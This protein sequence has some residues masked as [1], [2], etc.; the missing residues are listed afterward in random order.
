LNEGKL[1]MRF[2]VQ[3]PK[4]TQQAI[5]ANST[6]LRQAH[7]TQSRDMNSILHLQRTIGNQGV[8]LLLW[9][10]AEELNAGLTGTESPHVGHDF[11]RIPIH[12]PIGGAIQTKL[13]INTPGDDYE[14]D[15]D[16]VADQVVRM[17]EPQL[18]RTSACGGSCPNRITNQG[19]Q[20][21]LLTKH[22]QSQDISET[23]VPPIIE[24]VMSSPGRSLDSTTRRFME[25]RFGYDF[26]SVRVHSDARAAQSAD[27]VSA[28]A[29]AVGNNLVFCRG[30]Y[31]PETAQGR[32]LIAHELAHVVQQR[33][34]IDPHPVLRR[35]PKKAKTSAGEFV[36][37]PYDLTRVLGHGGATIGHGADITIKFKSNERV[38]A[39]KIAFVQTA[40]S[41]KDGKVHNRFSDEKKKKV[42]ESRMIPSGK[43]GEGTHIDQMPD[44]ST[45]LYGT[46]GSRGVDLSDPEP[47]KKLTEIGWHYKD[48]RGNVK[49]HDAMLHDEPDL[50]SGDIYTTAD[51]VM[52][53][54][55]GQQFE[56]SALAIAGNQKGTFY[57]TVEWGWT[58]GLSDNA[59]LLDFKVKSENVPS[60]V[61]I[62]AAKLWNVSVTADKKETIDLPVDVRVTSATAELWDSPDQ[63]K[64]IA[65][66]A[67]DTPLGRTAMV[68]PKGRVG[69]ASVIVTHGKN[70]GK[71]GWVKELDLN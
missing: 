68:D 18:Q 38:D 5:P 36:A 54:K 19:S 65:T 4:A 3:K 22:M 39:Q 41:I 69:W 34:S 1:A 2:F 6:I 25:P 51:D 50:N 66:L 31:V 42:A 8:Q 12:S 11:S 60:P 21:Q 29:Y 28:R 37:D 9:R 59:R 35:A 44:I 48:A 15:A 32:S 10:N 14:Q 40:L 71:T 27:A 62:E 52:K 63:R 13:A 20:G 49:D 58:R 55:W 70:I 30:E 16:R 26:S 45:P 57:G 24:Q 56:T 64:K 46:T 67:K 53:G 33:N 61:F 7:F 47:A 17:P 23:A 43:P